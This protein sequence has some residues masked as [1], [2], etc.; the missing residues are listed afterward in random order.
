MTR[1]NQTGETSIIFD[2]DGT[3]ADSMDVAIDIINDMHIVDRPV[4]RD[5]YERTK[6][7]TIPAI[8]K[9]FGVPLWRAPQLVVR[10]RSEITKRIHEI[11]LFDGMNDAINSLAIHHSLYVMSSNSLGNVRKFLEQ[12]N[13]RRSF[14]QI[15]GGAGVFGKTKA[16]NRV[17]RQHKLDKQ[18]TYYIGDE[19]RD[20]VAA[21][22]AGLKSVAV[23]WGFNGEE[24][25]TAQ[26]PDYIVRTPDELMA[27][28]AKG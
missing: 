23:T 22:K 12:H 3:L 21:K 17:V 24:I 11:P 9:E 27:I 18:C 8:F 28:F 2:L 7:L 19:V 5:D 26:K 13:I 14:D 1:S 16:L 20:I 4:T 15:Y 10:A 25:L 6:N